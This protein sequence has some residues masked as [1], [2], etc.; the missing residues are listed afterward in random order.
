MNIR[1]KIIDIILSTLNLDK[2]NNALE[3]GCMFNTN[4]GLS[5]HSN[6]P[7]GTTEWRSF[8][9]IDNNPDH[10]SSCKRILKEL[11]NDFVDEINFICS[12]SLAALSQIKDQI[13]ILDFCLIDGGAHPDVSL[14]EFEWCIKRISK[15]GAILVDDIH[16]LN[17]TSNYKLKREFGKGTLI[18]PYLI[19][20]EFLIGEKRSFYSEWIRFLG[21]VEMKLIISNIG[22]MEMIISCFWLPVVSKYR[23]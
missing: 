6:F 4:E 7:K 1:S 20:N 17:P 9:S 23:K 10:I 13:K 16:R 21:Q 15:T 18:I 12:D 5:T 11:N 22:F 3:I 19:A 8:F 14:S 2:V